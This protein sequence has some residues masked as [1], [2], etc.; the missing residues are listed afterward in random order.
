MGPKSSDRFLYKRR[1]HRGEGQVKMGS[2]IGVMLPQ[3]KEHLE[4]SKTGG[5]KETFFPRN[6][7]GSIALLTH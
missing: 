7:R 2:E 6:F 3:A 5:G 1:G 4:P